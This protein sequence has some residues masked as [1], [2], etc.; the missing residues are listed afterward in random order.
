MAIIQIP[1]TTLEPIGCVTVEKLLDEMFASM[2]DDYREDAKIQAISMALAKY[3]Q[4]YP[5]E[6]IA[7]VSGLETKLSLPT[8]WIKG[9]SHIKYI[10]FPLN[11]T[12]PFYLKVDEFQLYTTPSNQEIRLLNAQIKADELARI[13]YTTA[14]K[15]SDLD[16]NG[17]EAVATWAASLLCEQF[18]TRYAASVDSTISADGVSHV[19]KSQ[20]FSSRVKALRERYE[21]IVGKKADNFPKAAC[22]VVNLNATTSRGR[23]FFTHSNRW[24]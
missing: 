1:Q 7:D 21:Q 14:W 6:T 23:D 11:Q 15:E 16:M 22:A 17:I 19:S 4:D 9:K 13:T 10:E 24:R 5:R 3:S 18:A 20:N 8:D 2:G 12:P